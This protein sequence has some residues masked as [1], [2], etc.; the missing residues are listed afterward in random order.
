MTVML[1]LSIFDLIIA[2]KTI[3]TPNPYLWYMLYPRCHTGSRHCRVYDHTT[4]DVFSNSFA[5]ILHGPHTY[6][7]SNSN[8]IQT[9]HIQIYRT[10]AY[11]WSKIV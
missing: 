10:R 1:Q 9:S 2:N 5:I 11:T 6:K 8:N 4:T 7:A 3:L